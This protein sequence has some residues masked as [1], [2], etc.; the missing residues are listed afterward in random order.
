MLGGG[1]GMG[2]T[3]TGL[4]AESIIREHADYQ[5]YKNKVELRT[6]Y[7]FPEDW[8]VPRTEWAGPPALDEALTA[9][10][11]DRF[12]V[13]LIASFCGLGWGR[14]CAA[15]DLKGTNQHSTKKSS[16]FL[17]YVASSLFQKKRTWS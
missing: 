17:C 6:I 13:G 7:C 12:C 5:E 2:K 8:G 9:M 4:Q 16:G 14:I 3:R 11:I 1:S 15:V 10:N